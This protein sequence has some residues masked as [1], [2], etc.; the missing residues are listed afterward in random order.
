MNVHAS[1]FAGQWYPA[2]AGEMERL[3]AGA[4]ERSCQRTGPFLLPGGSGFVVPHAG[5]AYS[6]TVAAA[7]YRALAQEKP[8]RIILLG[9]PHHGGLSGVAAPDVDAIATPFG[10][11]PVDR[12]FGAAFPSVAEE[13]ICDHSVEIQL[14]FLQNAVPGARIVPL[15]VGQ[16]DREERAAA[17]DVLAHAWKPG[18]VLVASSDFTHYGRN[19]GYVPFPP[20]SAAREHL[21]LLDTEYLEAAGSLDSELFLRD[22]AERGGTV[23]GTGPISLLIDVLARLHDGNLYPS[24]LDY[25]TS[26]EITGDFHH[27]VSYAALAF[28]PSKAFEVS[29]ADRDALLAS[30]SQTLESLRATGERRPISVEN[31]SIVLRTRRGLFVTL[32]RGDELLGCIGNTVGRKPLAEDV[33]ALT[34]SAAL[35]DPRFRPAAEMEGPID[36]EISL[37][38][39]MRRLSGMEGFRAGVHGGFLRRG[40]HA[41]LLLPQVAT[42][43]GWGREEFLEA[44]VRKS[45][46]SGKA[47]EDPKARLYVFEAQVF[48]TRGE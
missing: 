34:L 2:D 42:E 24:T 5:P 11:V 12:P 19:F 8:E 28:H 39:P 31:P 15:Y 26:G 17:A 9:F 32:N 48:G 30:A 29:A 38:T 18:T 41:G 27:S 7:V 13:R 23:C 37:L 3:L 22:L 25:Q 14:P 6:G 16:M 45:R 44:L 1:P 35:D 46:L 47:W 20:D 33:A 4:F 40:A 10:A 21:R 43:Y 36:I